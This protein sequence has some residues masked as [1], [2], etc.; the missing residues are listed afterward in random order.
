MNWICPEDHAPLAAEPGRGTLACARCG[1]GYPVIDGVPLFARNAAEREKLERSSPPLDELWQA[2][3]DKRADEAATEFC[4]SHGC[5]RS[6]FGGD[7]KFLFSVPPS[8]TV[9]ELGAGFGDGTLGL[10]GTSHATVSIV[11]SLTHARIVRRYLGER[12]DRV[13]SV[14]VAQ[15]VRRLPLAD[16]SV[17]AVVFEDASASGFGLSNVRMREAAAEW[18]RVL[19][20][21]GVVFLGLANGLFRLPGLG[22]VRGSLR[23]RP[24]RESLDRLLKRRAVPGESR[25]IGVHRTVR[26]LT[27]LGFRRPVA[28]A[29]LPDENDTAVV[30]PVDDPRVVRYFLDNLVRKNS[31]AV[32]AALRAAHLL[33][34]LGLFRHCVPYYYLIFRGE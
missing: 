19:A 9:L 14:A 16:G 33:V 2:M 5:V 3:R 21:A 1:R 28:Y 17:H 8:G 11:P 15:D 32:R 6:P 12:S 27:A 23:A 24:H 10:A 20:P 18:K 31:M 34:T 29:P 26:T 7:C 22:Y 25:R 13:W 30:M 4:R